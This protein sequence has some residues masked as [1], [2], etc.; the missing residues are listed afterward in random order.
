MKINIENSFDYSLKNITFRAVDSTYKLRYILGCLKDD[1]Y[2]K[3]PL[4]AALVLLPLPNWRFYNFFSKKCQCRVKLK[5]STS[6]TY[7]RYIQVAK[8]GEFWPNMAVFGGGAAPA[9][10][11]AAV[12]YFV[13]YRMLVQCKTKVLYFR[14]ICK[15]LTRNSLKLAQKGEFWPKMALS[16]GFGGGGRC[17]C[18]GFMIF[19]VQDVSL[20]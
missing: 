5:F 10:A 14:N 6:R 11:N 17:Q 19:T 9:A 4:S 18:G 7:V 12:L 3:W 8:K 2:R 20:E 16:G 1:F 15:I 13:Q